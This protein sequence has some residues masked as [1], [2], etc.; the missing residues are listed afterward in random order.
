MAPEFNKLNIKLA[1]Y[2]LL[3]D[4]GNDHPGVLGHQLV[5]KPLKV[6]ISPLLGKAI[7]PILR[8]GHQ[9]IRGIII[10]LLR[11]ADADFRVG[12]VFPGKGLML[13]ERFIGGLGGFSALGEAGGQGIAPM[14]VDGRGG[15]RGVRDGFWGGEKR[16]ELLRKRE[17]G[18]GKKGRKR[19]E[20]EEEGRGGEGREKRK[21]MK[22]NEMK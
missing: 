10:H 19:E 21:E 7:P 12:A 16:T 22:R 1:E 2:P 11:V 15:D 4:R 6:L 17:R 14:F 20:E 3:R 13:G 5:I 8:Q 9:L 18:R